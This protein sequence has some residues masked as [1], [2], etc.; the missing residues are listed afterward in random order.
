MSKQFASSIQAPAR[1]DVEE[2]NLTGH[3]YDGIVEYDNP[4]PGW[5]K[6]LFWFFVLIAPLYY[7]YFQ[8][9]VEGRSIHDEYNRHLAS[10]F[11]IRFSEIG[12]LTAD[13]ATILEYMNEKDWLA[14]GEVVYKSNCVSCHGADGGGLVGPNLTDDYWKH[15]TSVENIANVIENGAAN[16]AMPAWKTRFSHPNQIVLLTAYIASLRK[17]PVAGKPPEGNEISGWEE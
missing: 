11:E 17:N 5:W 12:E 13:R 10:V 6:F 16:S 1:V 7:F 8:G 15:V 14:V 3:S 4:L 2:S 9:G